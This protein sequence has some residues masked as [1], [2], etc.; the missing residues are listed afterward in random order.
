MFA[1][2][3]LGALW[4]LQTVFLQSFYD[5]MAIQNTQ[6][7]AEKIVGQVDSDD[8]EEQLDAW[9]SE[10]SML[11]FLTD[12]EGGILYSTDEHSAVYQ[13]K[14][15]GRSGGSN[16][17]REQ[18]G[19][20]SWQEGA[21]H[22]LPSD[23]PGFLEC[24]EESSTGQAGYKSVDGNAYIYGQVL[25]ESS[26]WGQAVLYM[27]TPLG[28]AGAA[29]GILRVQL[30]W[31]TLASLALASVLAWLVARQFARPVAAITRQARNLPDGNTEAPY[32]AGFC[33]ELDEVS[34]ALTETAETLRN[35]ENA[36][37]E[38]LANV[39]HDLRTPLTMIK[40]Y[41]EMVRE[42]SWNDEEKREQDLGIITREA[43]RL[44]TL[45]NDILEYSA[46][47]SQEPELTRV[48]LSRLAKE[49]VEQ[50]APLAQQNG[51]KI[52]SDIA[53]GVQVP[54]DEKHM[55]RVLC[56]LL[57]NGL[58]YT[59]SK[60]TVRVKAQ[61]GTV[62]AEVR[63]DG[64]GIPPEELPLVW[65]RYFTSKQRG[66]R[67]SSGLGLAITKELLTAQKARFGV[68]SQVGDGTAF[69]FEMPLE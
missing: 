32:E 29:V 8:F 9:A 41:A 3:I 66:G 31:V 56:N 1:A 14:D 48:D 36:R 65:E 39:S 55:S 63:D 61:E 68:S 12:R 22:N 69:W 20:L 58:R 53:S 46:A 19:P 51:L 44:T 37:R 54:A 16:P 47:Q 42:I 67:G 59:Q 64:P 2:L 26:R 11:I 50:V 38:L 28:G 33:K 7:L 34:R 23:Y 4:L 13:K 24:L 25:P 27:S 43:D 30:L 18:D 45:V 52:V 6:R 10:G 21:R 57:D 17:Y 60:L 35:L 49:A 62:R 40:G 15:A 5:G